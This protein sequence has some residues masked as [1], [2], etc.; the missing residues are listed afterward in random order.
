MRPKLPIVLCIASN[1]CGNNVLDC[2]GIHG[3]AHYPL[4]WVREKPW[5]QMDKTHDVLPSNAAY[6]WMTVM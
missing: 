2:M 3:D 5:S 4:Q 6:L 1:I